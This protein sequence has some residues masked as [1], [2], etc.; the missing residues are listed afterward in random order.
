M[1]DQQRPPRSRGGWIWRQHKNTFEIT[2]PS[3]TRINW[4]IKCA[5]N[6]ANPAVTGP[7]SEQHT[8]C[9]IGFGRIVDQQLAS[10][11]ATEFG[12]A[13]CEGGQQPSASP[14]VGSHN[15]GMSAGTAEGDVSDLSRLVL[16]LQAETGPVC[17]VSL[18]LFINIIQR[19]HGD[20]SVVELSQ[21]GHV[22][23]GEWPNNEVSTI[24]GGL[25]VSV[26][27]ITRARGIR[28][29]KSRASLR[30]RVKGVQPLN[31]TEQ[32]CLACGG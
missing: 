7:R 10:C 12:P 23:F 8:H 25:S 14:L 9:L 15:D 3:P 32:N 31:R 22:R 16:R 28:G 29:D 21:T 18:G 6:G 17:L 4:E 30:V 26:P 20:R 5:L 19:D 1:K 24:L 27:N 13:R 2:S 11:F